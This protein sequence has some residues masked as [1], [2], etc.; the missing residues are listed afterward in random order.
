MVQL[1]RRV[2]RLAWVLAGTGWLLAWAI[3][4]WLEP[5]TPG[6]LRTLAA[7][8]LLL[9]P[10]TWWV[11]RAPARRGAW[12]AYFAL[13][14]VIAVANIAFANPDL[15][16]LFFVL[17]LLRLVYRD[18]HLHL[19]SPPLS[20]A[21]YALILYVNPDHRLNLTDGQIVVR[22]FILFC[23]HALSFVI[24]ASVEDIRARPARTALRLLG[25]YALKGLRRRGRPSRSV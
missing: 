14:G 25:Q 7:G 24:N 18:S 13:V 22:L 20:V 19:V 9:I 23:F 16:T 10:A 2:M 5:V 17:G 1:N 4:R 11:R 8:T 6:A 21:L 3:D 15:W 12:A